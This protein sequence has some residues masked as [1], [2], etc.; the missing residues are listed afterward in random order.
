MQTHDQEDL[1][2][3]RPLDAVGELWQALTGRQEKPDAIVDG[4]ALPSRTN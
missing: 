1:V 2:A 3:R 4:L